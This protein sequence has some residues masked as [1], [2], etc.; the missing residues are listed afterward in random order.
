MFDNKNRRK[1]ARLQAKPKKTTIKDAQKKLNR[2]ARKFEEIL[3]RHRP[4]S[5][6]SYRPTKSKKLK[7]N[8]FKPI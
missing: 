4:K 8:K 2:E 1:S 3:G 7:F 5:R 6:S